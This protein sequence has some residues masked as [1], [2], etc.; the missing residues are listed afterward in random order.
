MNGNASLFPKILTAEEMAAMP[1]R[2]LEI[3]F[4][5]AE[6]W[7]ETMKDRFLKAR[8]QKDIEEEMG[9]EF[10]AMLAAGQTGAIVRRKMGWRKYPQT[11]QRVPLSTYLTPQPGDLSEED[12]ARYTGRLNNGGKEPDDNG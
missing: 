10:G 3:Y 4:H 7:I 1:V 5:E 12:W 9:E 6:L 11:Q 2:E 8:R